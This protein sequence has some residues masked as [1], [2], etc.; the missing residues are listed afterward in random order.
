M[1]H[2]SA[3]EIESKWLG[4]TEKIIKGL[5]SLATMVAPSIIFIDE[6]DSMF[7]KR[8][9]DDADW[10]RSRVNM[11]LGQTDGLLKADRPPFLLL[12]T[13]HP[14]ELDEA[15][16]RRVPGRLYIGLPTQP[17]RKNLL[18]IFLREENME[19]EMRLGDIA[20]MTSG[21]SGSDLQNLCVQAALVSQ[22]EARGEQQQDG[23]RTLR[24]AHFEEAMHRCGPTVSGDAI[25]AIRDFARKFDNNAVDKVGYSY[26][27]AEVA[28]RK[29]KSGK[30]AP[31]TWRERGTVNQAPNWME[32]EEVEIDETNTLSF[33][34]WKKSDM[35]PYVT[36]ELCQHWWQQA[37]E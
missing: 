4:E 10:V 28:K 29:D 22:G 24:F 19:P 31:H 9:S 6:A 5:F 26:S 11:F 12:A 8:R 17:A 35:Y 3:A 2:V 15:V 14:N 7:Y 21:F 30:K 1:I 13:N 25:D 37:Q 36:E 32:I 23:K 27:V 34:D 20:A 16:L 18:A 33:D